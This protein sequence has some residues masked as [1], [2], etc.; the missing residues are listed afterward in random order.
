MPR[1]RRGPKK[2]PVPDT[3]EITPSLE[4]DGSNERTD[5]RMAVTMATLTAN[6]GTKARLWSR[7]RVVRS[8]ANW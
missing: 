3:V 4:P 7:P 5:A 1:M 2:A 8:D 6:L